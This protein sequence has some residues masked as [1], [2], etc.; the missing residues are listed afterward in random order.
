MFTISIHCFYLNLEGNDAPIPDPHNSISLLLP[1]PEPRRSTNVLVI[2][3]YNLRSSAANIMASSP[4]ARV[5]SLSTPDTFVPQIPTRPSRTATSRPA[6][7]SIP[8]SSIRHN[9]C[10]R[11]PPPMGFGRV[12]SGRSQA[13]NDRCHK[14]ADRCHRGS[15]R[16]QNMESE[17]H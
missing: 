5:E 16:S 6:A 14:A 8:S 2:Q 13:Q 15:S 17:A 9:D 3:C 11:R 10:R 1:V 12:S 7:H 4:P